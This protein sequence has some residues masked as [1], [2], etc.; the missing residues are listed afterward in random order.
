MDVCIYQGEWTCGRLDS[1]NSCCMKLGA[2][3]GNC[4]LQHAGTGSREL[5]DRAFNRLM[6][7]GRVRSAM[8]LL[9]EHMLV[10]S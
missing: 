7:L 5:I 9:T 3:T 8:R 6:L 4:Q 2:V 1:S 10:E